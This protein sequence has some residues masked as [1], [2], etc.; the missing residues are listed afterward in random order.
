VIVPRLHLDEEFFALCGEFLKKSGDTERTI[1]SIRQ[2][3]VE[4]EGGGFWLIKEE[5]GQTICYFF[6]E[7]RPSEYG[8]LVCLIHQV[9]VSA[10]AKRKWHWLKQV[11]G[12]LHAWAKAHG[13][14]QLVFYTRRSPKAFVRALDNGW[15][16]ESVVLSRKI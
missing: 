15:E 4:L 3:I 13:A 6:A 10:K 8:T 9:V 11:D 2:Q 5:G 12:Y 1:D 16:V 7:I 14:T